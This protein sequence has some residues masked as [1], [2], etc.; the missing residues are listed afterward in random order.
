MIPVPSTKDYLDLTD[1]LLF[2]KHH[3]TPLYIAACPIFKWFKILF[4]SSRRSSHLSV[5]NPWVAPWLALWGRN[6]ETGPSIW[7]MESTFLLLRRVQ[8]W[9][10]EIFTNLGAFHEGRSQIDSLT[11]SSRYLGLGTSIMVTWGSSN[12]DQVTWKEKISWKNKSPWVE[13]KCWGTTPAGSGLKKSYKM[14]GATRRG[15]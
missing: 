6:D 15:A 10:A 5:L 7:L 3:K 11:S 8:R 4:T 13:R 14:S 9:K 12:S 2:V 1:L